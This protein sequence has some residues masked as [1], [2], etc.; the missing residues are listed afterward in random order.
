MNNSLDNVLIVSGIIFSTYGIFSLLTTWN[1]DGS[2]EWPTVVILII[3]ITLL[4][5]GRMIKKQQ[6]KKDTSLEILTKKH[7]NGEI[8]DEEFD[9]GFKKFS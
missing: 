9:V 5:V 2:F 8:S 1:G 7:N 3:G 6:L 4:P